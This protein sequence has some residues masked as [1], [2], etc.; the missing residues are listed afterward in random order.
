MLPSRTSVSYDE[1]YLIGNGF[2]KTLVAVWSEKRIS[3]KGFENG[4]PLNFR[5]AGYGRS[6]AQNRSLSRTLAQDDFDMPH[7]QHVILTSKGNFPGFR[8][9][10]TQT[11]NMKHLHFFPVGVRLKFP[12]AS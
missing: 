2:S 11:P 1:R 12:R 9:T 4:N 5:C 10:A 8:S 7:D 3:R 6:P